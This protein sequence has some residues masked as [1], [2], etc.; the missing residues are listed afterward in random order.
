MTMTLKQ[1]EE[2]SRLIM[3]LNKLGVITSNLEYQLSGY[4]NARWGY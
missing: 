3:F 4:M 1:A 2:C